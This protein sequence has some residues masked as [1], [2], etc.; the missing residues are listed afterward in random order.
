MLIITASV[1]RENEIYFV[2]S[3]NQRSRW[4]SDVANKDHLENVRLCGEEAG[5]CNTFWSSL[6]R[7]VE[8][9]RQFELDPL[10]WTGF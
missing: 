5:R 3:N 8:Q 10:G 6:D 4:Q 9:D 7:W 1:R 2:S